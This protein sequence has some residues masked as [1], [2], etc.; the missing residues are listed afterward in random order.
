MNIKRRIRWALFHTG[1][2]LYD[3]MTALATVFAAA[4]VSCVIALA[5]FGVVPV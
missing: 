4:I 3:L 1:H 5:V 2:W